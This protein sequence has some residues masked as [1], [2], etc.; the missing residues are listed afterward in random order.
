MRAVAVAVVLI[1]EAR[2]LT[3][4]QSTAVFVCHAVISLLE[5]KGRYWIS[6]SRLAKY[7]AVLL[8]QDDVTL[9]MSATLNLVTLLP[10][11]QLNELQHDCLTPIKQV[12]SSPPN[13]QDT[14]LSDSD[15]ELYTD[16]SSFISRGKQCAGYATVTRDHVLEAK[17]LAYKAS[18]LKVKLIAYWHTAHWVNETQVLRRQ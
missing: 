15:L 11:S 13:L 5:K 12:Y 2:K 1:E 6:P 16:G 7:Q 9:C 18:A 3:L 14:C 8:K 10:I 17:P 4:G